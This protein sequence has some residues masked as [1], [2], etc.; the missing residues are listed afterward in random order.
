MRKEKGWRA[1]YTLSG[2]RRQSRQFRRKAELDGGAFA[3]PP[4][5]RATGCGEST[6]AS[7]GAT[8]GARR[9]VYPPGA[10]LAPTGMEEER[11]SLKPTAVASVSEPWSDKARRRGLCPRSVVSRRRRGRKQATA[12]KAGFCPPPQTSP[13]GTIPQES[14][15]GRRSASDCARRASH[16]M[17]RVNAPT[18]CR[19]R[20][21]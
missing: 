18:G 19:G 14:G 17:W 13:I 5:G 2:N 15:I 11:L 10:S 4:E 1:T 7:R 12:C 8:Q 16:R 20:P 21:S 6:L 9:A 3:T